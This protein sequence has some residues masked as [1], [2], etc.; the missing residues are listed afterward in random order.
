MELSQHETLGQMKLSSVTQAVTEL[1]YD[2]F[3]EL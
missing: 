1:F 2:I 3:A